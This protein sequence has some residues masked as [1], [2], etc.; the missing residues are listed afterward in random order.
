[1]LEIIGNFD[2]LDVY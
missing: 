2:F 1:M